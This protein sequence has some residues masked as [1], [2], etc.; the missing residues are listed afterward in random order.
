MYSLRALR[1]IKIKMSKVKNYLSLIKFSH[2]IFAMPFALI[3]FFLGLQTISETKYNDGQ[4]NLNKTISLQWDLEVGNLPFSHNSLGAKI[5]FGDATIWTI[6]RYFFLVI[7]CMVFARSAAMAFNRYLDRSFDA[8][9]PRT[10]IREIP[11]GIIKANSVLWFTIANC[12]LFITTCFFINKICFYLSPVAL[13]IVLGYS[14]TKRF[15]P[16][17][18][19]ILG[20]GLS[21]API[22]AYLAVTGFFHWLPILFSLAVIFWVSGFDIIYALQDEEFDKSQNLYS[23]PAWLGKAKALRVSEILHLL[24]ATA[25]IIAG[26]YGGFG[27]LYWIGVAV[28]TVMLGYQH[29]IVKPNDLKRVNLAFMTVNGIASVVFAIFVISDLFN[30]NQ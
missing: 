1:E 22:G 19:L 30:S 3:G 13:L 29:S 27:W 20:L 28:F 23:I 18:H 14:Y 25:V 4:W 10:G 9:N 11:A 6:G 24:S 5:A 21:L 17:C 8:K 16:F 15:T 26:T 12:L 2:T 7:L